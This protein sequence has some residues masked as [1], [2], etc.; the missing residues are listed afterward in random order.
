MQYYSIASVLAMEILRS[1]IKPSIS[2]F[3]SMTHY[4]NKANQKIDFTNSVVYLYKYD[5]CVCL[6][7]GMFAIVFSII[8]PMIAFQKHIY[9][10]TYTYMYLCLYILYYKCH[11]VTGDSLLY[12][13]HIV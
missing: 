3:L 8:S 7:Y 6:V 10:H 11:I 9:T 4:S 1:S 12:C 5:I 13:N 2:I